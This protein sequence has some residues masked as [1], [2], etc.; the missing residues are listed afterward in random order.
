MVDLNLKL[1][2]FYL[3]VCAKAGD[4]RR[5]LFREGIVTIFRQDNFIKY[6]EESVL[7]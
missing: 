5:L 7:N 2:S 3:R 6:F 1:N 4:T